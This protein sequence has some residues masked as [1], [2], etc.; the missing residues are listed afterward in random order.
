MNFDNKTKNA[1]NNVNPHPTTSTIR[2]YQIQ[3]EV[4]VHDPALIP[5]SFGHIEYFGKERIQ[6]IGCCS[7]CYLKPPPEMCSGPF[8]RTLT[9]TSI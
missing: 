1:T 3:T 4:S 2:G 9:T 5:C 7:R 8:C 6:R